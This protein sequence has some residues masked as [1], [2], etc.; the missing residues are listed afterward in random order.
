MII[1]TI[2]YKQLYVTNNE[3]E[4]LCSTQPLQ[5]LL[6]RKEDSGTDATSLVFSLIRQSKDLALFIKLPQDTWIEE[7]SRDKVA[8][9][10]TADVVTLAE[11]RFDA[12]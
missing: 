1:L 9:D 4:D 11:G 5:S 10:S 7:Y 3:C 12:H 2:N 8:N 6:S